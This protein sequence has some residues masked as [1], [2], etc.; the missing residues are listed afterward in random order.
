ME[1]IHKSHEHQDDLLTKKKEKKE[2]EHYRTRYIG[3]RLGDKTKKKNKRKK[4]CVLH[5]SLCITKTE[6]CDMKSYIGVRLGDKTKKI[7]EKKA[8][9]CTAACVSQRQNYVI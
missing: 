3:V 6:L 2:I 9:C 5:S 8:V 1:N 7:K 4:G